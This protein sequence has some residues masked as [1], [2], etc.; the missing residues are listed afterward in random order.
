MKSGS[1]EALGAAIFRGLPCGMASAGTLDD[2]PCGMAKDRDRDHGMVKVRDP[3]HGMAKDR[4]RA[5]GMTTPPSAALGTVK[6]PPG[7][8]CGTTTFPRGEVLVMARVRDL[9]C[10][11]VKDRHALVLAKA[12]HRPDRVPRTTDR[13]ECHRSTTT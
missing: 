12:T 3:A 10:V 4:V 5:R 2:L 6:A 11:T 7:R 1:F 9:L 13:R 8:T